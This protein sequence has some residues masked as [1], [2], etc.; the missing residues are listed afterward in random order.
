LIFLAFL[1]GKPLI[2]QQDDLAGLWQGYDG[3]FAHVSRHLL[4]LA[5][6]IPADKYSFKPA[7]NVRTTAQVFMH[8]AMANFWLLS[9]TG[10]KPPADFK[11]ELEDTVSSKPEVISWLKRS[12][13]AVKNAHAS[14]KPA[15]LQRHVTVYKREATVDGMYL[16]ILVHT[17][18]HYGQLIAYART[19]G[20]APPWSK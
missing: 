12:F 9:Y 8:I 11:V 16:R 13:E 6:A 20:V 5:D 1:C 18:E 2:A 15:D 4:A 14:V 10:N 19:M 17:N 7:P 3:E